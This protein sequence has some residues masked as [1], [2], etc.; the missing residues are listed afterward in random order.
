VC[1]GCVARGVNQG[2]AGKI[3]RR[4][5]PQK[6]TA[7]KEHTRGTRSQTES[8]RGTHGD[9]GYVF[10]VWTGPRRWVGTAYTTAAVPNTGK[11]STRITSGPQPATQEGHKDAARLFGTGLHLST[12]TLQAAHPLLGP[13]GAH[14]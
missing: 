3:G 5:T 11:C 4:S 9:V 1:H 6:M 10:F 8:T 14:V 2:G 7:S 13:F 12:L